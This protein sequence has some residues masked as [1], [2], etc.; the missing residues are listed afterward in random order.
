MRLSK[1]LN[2]SEVLPGE[3]ADVRPS[4]PVTPRVANTVATIPSATERSP[5]GN[6]MIRATMT[7]ASASADATVMHAAKDGISSVPMTESASS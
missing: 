5:L 4:A 7:A 3:R 2:E 1:R 6:G